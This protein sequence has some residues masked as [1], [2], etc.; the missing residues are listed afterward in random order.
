MLSWPGCL[1]TQ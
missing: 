1:L